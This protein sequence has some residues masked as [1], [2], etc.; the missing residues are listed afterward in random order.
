MKTYKIAVIPGDGIG[1]EVT[2]SAVAVLKKA[3]EKSG[4]SFEFTEC[5]AG[6]WK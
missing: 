4:F 1:P 2:S 3:G 6:G 5:D